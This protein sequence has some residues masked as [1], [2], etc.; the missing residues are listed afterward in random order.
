MGCSLNLRIMETRES[1]GDA[2]R[3]HVHGAGKFEN[4]MESHFCSTRSVE[5][6]NW[7]DYISE[8]A[9]ATS[10]TIH[11]QLV[12]FMSVYFPHFVCADPHF[13]AIEKY[14]KS[15]K[16]IQIVGGD[17]N[18]ELVPGIG[19]ERVSVGPHT[20]KEVNKRGDWV[21]Q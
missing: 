9:L 19:V 17:F 15:K 11:E 8:R 7:T 5:N 12:L 1:W 21:K 3:T 6:V 2:T 13:R 18:T 20:L 4:S 14:T 10:I 16:A